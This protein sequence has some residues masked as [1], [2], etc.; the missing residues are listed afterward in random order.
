MISYLIFDF[1]G[2]VVDSASLYVRLAN[3]LA[4]EFNLPRKDFDEIKSFSGMTIKDRCKMLDI[5]LYRLPAMS[6]RMQ[7]EIRNYIFELQWIDGIDDEIKKL[8]K[9]GFKLAIISSNSAANIKRFLKD[10]GLDVFDEI[11]SSKGLFDKHISI[12]K[13]IRKLRI[14]KNEVVYIGDE[15]RD[16]RAC[17]RSKIKIISVT[18][19]F[20]S[21]ELLARGN[22]DY[23][24]HTPQELT[25][26]ILQIS[27]MDV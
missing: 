4:E 18:W 19:G 9:M 1:D 22:P 7:E 20:D 12:N 27:K 2:T 25:D 8:K 15:Y 24:A 5:P 11:Y 16:I 6:I 26:I 13:L 10:K 3:N 14:K 21:K 17:K 23:I